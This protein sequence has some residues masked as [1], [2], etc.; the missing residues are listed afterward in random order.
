MSSLPIS[1]SSTN[2]PTAGSEG[3]VFFE[4]S[5]NKIIVKKAD[6]SFKEIDTDASRQGSVPAGVLNYPGGLYADLTGTYVLE[7]APALH[8][9]SFDPEGTLRGTSYSQGDIVTIWGDCSGNGN[10][11]I[12]Q[13]PSN[14]SS[15]TLS[16]VNGY[17]C[18]EC[19]TAA[20][21]HYEPIKGHPM[22]RTVCMVQSGSPHVTPFGDYNWGRGSLVNSVYT[23]YLFNKNLPAKGVDVSLASIRCGQLNAGGNHSLSSIPV[24]DWNSDGRASHSSTAAMVTANTSSVTFLHTYAMHNFEF[25]FFE[26]ILT[27]PEMNTVFD[28]LKNKYDGLGNISSFLASPLTLS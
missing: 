3:S 8:F 23:N 1:Q 9:S 16:N 15:P 28:Y 18:V 26:E 14:S 11:A 12:A 5:S 13:D 25:L 20:G 6:G 17:V 27:L 22:I 4:P 7:K 2:R 24:H 21:T 10:H 19:G